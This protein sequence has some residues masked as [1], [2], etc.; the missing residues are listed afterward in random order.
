MPSDYVR[1][2]EKEREINAVWLPLQLV[3]LFKGNKR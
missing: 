2:R 3:E 1:E